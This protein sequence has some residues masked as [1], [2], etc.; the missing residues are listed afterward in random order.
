MPKPTVPPL[1]IGIIGAGD[2]VR[3]KHLPG[4]S[5]IPG[6]KITAVSNSKMRSTER[7]CRECAPD[8]RRVEHWVDLVA[9]PEIDIVWIGTPP[10]LHAEI[11]V[12]AL[13]AGKHVFCQARMAMDLAQAE[14]MLAAARRNPQLVTMICPSPR[15][16]RTDVVIKRL[17]AEETLGTIHQL[18]LNSF[19]GQYLDTSKPAHW[20]QRAELS[21]FNVLTLGIYVEVL[22][23]WFGPITRVQARARVL[24]PQRAGYDVRIPDMVNVLCQ[25]DGGAEGVL[26]FSGVTPKAPPDRLEVYGSQGALVYD[27]AKDEILLARGITGAWER[28]HVPPAQMSEWAVEADFI[29]SVRSNGRLRPSP[30][31]EEG[32]RYMRVIQG[33]AD[34][35]ATGAEV[36]LPGAAE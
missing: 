16:L 19:H 26:E 9:D 28:V 12:A 5:K 4:L 15:G 13:E 8:A 25:F 21:G 34:S 27:F 32:V 31:F 7:F 11:T 1:R 23:R 17:L 35:L 10:Y 14:E 30:D 24:T 36:V 20:R 6:V 3:E 29:A 18:R 2:I 33:V 22:Q